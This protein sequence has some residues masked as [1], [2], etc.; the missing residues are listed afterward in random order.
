EPTV[1]LAGGPTQPEA[2]AFTPIGVTD[3]VDPFTGDFN[4]NI[5]LMDID[6]YP[7]NIAYSS[8]ASMDQEASWVGLGW[9]LNAGAIVRMM[10][11]LPDDFNGDVVEK[12]QST[13]PAFSL[14]INVGLSPEI[15]GFPVNLS[16]KASLTYHN[17]NGF[18]ATVGIGASFNIAKFNN[19]SLTGGFSLSGSSENGASFAPSISLDTKETKNIKTDISRSAT[20]GTAFNSRAGLQSLSY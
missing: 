20:V 8:G 17:Y 14:G 13:K 10:R 6:G 2:T 11:G 12:T 19:G 5:P 9:N 15:V 18:G 4:Y 16:G 1:A 7:I 3:M